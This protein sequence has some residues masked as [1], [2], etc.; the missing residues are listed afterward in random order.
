MKILTYTE[1]IEITHYE[2]MTFDYTKAMVSFSM[3]GYTRRL[4][5]DYIARAKEFIQEIIEALYRDCEEIDLSHFMFVTE[6]YNISNL[7]SLINNR[8]KNF[9][10]D[11]DK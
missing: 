8:I 5:F 2:K 10:P 3:E 1:T 9:N 6:C 11:D 4:Y 7:I